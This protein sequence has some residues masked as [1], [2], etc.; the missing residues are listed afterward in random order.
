MKRALLFLI[1]LESCIATTCV[2]AQEPVTPKSKHF[3]A[4]AV[5][6]P[7]AQGAVRDSEKFREFSTEVQRRFLPDKEELPSPI[8]QL[9]EPGIWTWNTVFDQIR[10]E[11][12]FQQKETT[13]FVLYVGHGGTDATTKK[14]FLTPH[15]R[16]LWQESD[17]LRERLLKF[18][19]RTTILVTD[20][21]S[22]ISPAV[23]RP[24]DVAAVKIDP[25]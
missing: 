25:I 24:P 16:Q 18:G 22:S 2:I 17:A 5:I 8:L 7:G 6:D 1:L 21:C 11:V 20:T 9:I 12:G 23:R 10:S 3:V 13:L 4:V 14:H 15:D 19:C